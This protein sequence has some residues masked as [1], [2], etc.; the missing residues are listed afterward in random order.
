MRASRLLSILLLLQNRGRSS[1]AALAR[2]FEV[3]VRTIYRDIDQLSATGVP[4]YAERGRGGGFALHEGYRTRLAALTAD[5][6]SALPLAPLGDAAAMIGAGAVARSAQLKLLASLPTES[7]RS[8]QRVAERIHLDPIAWYGRAETLD[9]LPALANAVWS[10]RSVTIEYESWRGRVTRKLA[11][12][13][14]VL[15]GGLWYLVAAQAGSMRTYRVS[16]ILVLETS[17]Q[18]FRR[19]PRF[20]LA[21]YWKESVAAFEQRL[22]RRRAR[23]RISP[24]GRRLLADFVPMWLAAA[25]RQSPDGT[26]WIEIELPIEDSAMTAKQLLRLG[27]EVEVLEPPEL[28]AALAEEAAAV[29]RLYRAPS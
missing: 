7:A 27:A 4:V 23:E 9:L 17:E 18:G 2:H 24:A 14:L 21:S 22:F 12:H 25:P 11:P 20:D 26:A 28:R 16:N 3:S 13:G 10:D 19:A 8:A 5:E 29:L 15:K 6:A 1:A